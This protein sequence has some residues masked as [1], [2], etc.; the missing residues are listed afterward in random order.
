MLQQNSLN[1][2]CRNAYLVYLNTLQYDIVLA[3]N[4]CHFD[5]STAIGGRGI[6]GF[7]GAPL[8]FFVDFSLLYINLIKFHPIEITDDLNIT[9][10]CYR[11]LF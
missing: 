3:I 10:Y 7:V 5:V 4:W 11:T 6:S 1:L 9:L 8:S 2:G